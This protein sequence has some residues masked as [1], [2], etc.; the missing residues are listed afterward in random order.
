MLERPS[1]WRNS[2]SA[3]SAAPPDRPVFVLDEGFPQPI[4]TEAIRRWQRLRIDIRP[5]DPSLHGFLD[6]RLI[7]ELR[8]RDVEGLITT[9]DAMVHRQEVLDAIE[10]TSFSVVTCKRAGAD[11]VLATGLL[12][13]HVAVIAADH[14]SDRP[15]IWRLGAARVRPVSAAQQRRTLR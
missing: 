8:G 14:R 7:R 5:L 2:S 12:F 11:A 4:L 1:T 3:T 6:H 10:E 15:Q 13:V 9:D